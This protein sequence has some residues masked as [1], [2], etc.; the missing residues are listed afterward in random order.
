[1]KKREYIAPQFDAV[2]I[3]AKSAL[4]AGS[5]GGKVAAP[6]LYDD[7]E[8]DWIQKAYGF[9]GWDLEDV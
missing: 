6:E 4:L 9:G 1:M 3:S 5:Y 7:D 8:N 2:E